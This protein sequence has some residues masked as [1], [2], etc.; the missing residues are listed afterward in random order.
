MNAQSAEQALSFARKIQVFQQ[1]RSEAMKCLGALHHP[2]RLLI[3]PT[4]LCPQ[5]C[6]SDSKN[7]NLALKLIVGSTLALFQLSTFIH[8]YLI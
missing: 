6:Q 8:L 1:L 3:C 2:S 5:S 4:Q 7:K